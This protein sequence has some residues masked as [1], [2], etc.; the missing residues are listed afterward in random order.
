[1][2]PGRSSFGVELEFIIAHI[3]SSEFN[4]DV[5]GNAVVIPPH[6]EFYEEDTYIYKQI[7][8]TLESILPTANTRIFTGGGQTAPEQDHQTWQVK[9]DCSLDRLLGGLPIPGRHWDVD[10]VGVEVTS[11][12]MWSTQESLNEVRNAVDLL[13]RTY[14]IVTSEACGFHIHVGQGPNHIPLTDLRR[15]AALFFAAD[16]LLAQLHP[17]HRLD[18][19]MCMGIRL[20]SEVAHGMTVAGTASELLQLHDVGEDAVPQDADRNLHSVTNIVVPDASTPPAFDRQIPRGMLHGYPRT[21]PGDGPR[22]PPTIVGRYNAYMPRGI[23][24]CVRELLSAPKY[25]VLAVLL[26]G[27][28]QM[29]GHRM[30]YNFSNYDQYKRR[31]PNMARTIEFRQPA[32]TLDADE[33]ISLAKA[34]IGLFEFAVSAPFVQLWSVI[35]RCA[36]ADAR[37]N[38]TSFDVLDL[39]ASA[40]LG[41]VAHDLQN[42]LLARD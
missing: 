33:I 32:G 16:P 15:A 6:I 31:D 25:D 30:A 26:Q 35:A 37:P 29:P 19:V 17:A 23:F 18:N 40:G 7:K 4:R 24:G 21:R 3:P 11:P 2:D 5:H 28:G 10:W 27:S 38:E 22:V 8:T 9:E 42:V 14:R 39:L 20:F 36:Q 12:A 34:H 1:M 41:D 13:K